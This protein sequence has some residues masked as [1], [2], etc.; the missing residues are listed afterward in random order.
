M[1][2]NYFLFVLFLNVISV[3]S[4]NDLC[5]N[6]IALTPN[7]NCVTTNGTFNGATIS[8]A[9]PSCASSASQD[10]WYSFVATD[11]TMSVTVFP[12]NGLNV[13][14][15]LL[16]SSCNGTSVVC[17]GQFGVGTAESY[18]NNNF[19]VGT[20]YF[21]RVL[22]A[23]SGL[24]TV[25]FSICVQRYPAPTNDLCSNALTVLPSNSCTSNTVTFNGATIS[26]SAPICATGASQD[27]WFKFVATNTIMTIQIAAS[28]GLNHGFEIIDASCTGTSIVCVNSN[29]AGVNESYIGAIF[30]AGNT[31]YVRIFNVSPTLS[32]NS[33]NFC[34]IDANLGSEDINK[35]KL[36]L[37]PNPTK[38]YINPL[39]EIKLIDF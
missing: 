39:G 5:S 23:S 34:V 33:F 15:D 29:G 36:S 7:T 4:Q 31:Y 27:V 1:K 3:F 26:N 38:E 16:E 18:F 6:A 19:T 20:T 11:P 32:T 10:V 8:D 28:N 22:N 14:F 12:L 24:S 35:F 2:I 25:G 21:I 37:F 30:S 9:A 13:A 17:V